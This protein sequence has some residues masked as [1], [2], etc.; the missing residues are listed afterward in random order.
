MS[1]LQLF[2]AWR[3]SGY[4]LTY[5]FDEH[6]KIPTIA[7]QT[8]RRNSTEIAFFSLINP[9]PK[10]LPV[11]NRSRGLAGLYLRPVE[12][13]AITGLDDGS[14]L[15]TLCEGNGSAAFAM[16]RVRRYDTNGAPVGMLA[17]IAFDVRPAASAASFAEF[18]RSWQSNHNSSNTVI[19]I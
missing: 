14:F 10:P 13:P 4:G 8:F 11:R 18:V 9:L 6:D 16:S 5:I 1:V 3:V 12:S 15:V 7:V 2:L 17:L 19:S